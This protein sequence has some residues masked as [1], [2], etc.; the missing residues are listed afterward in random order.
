MHMPYFG[1]T[2]YHAEI[3]DLKVAKYSPARNRR[4]VGKS[5]KLNSQGLTYMGGLVKCPRNAAPYILAN[6][7]EVL[8]VFPLVQLSAPLSVL[9]TAISLFLCAHLATQILSQ[10]LSWTISPWMESNKREG[11]MSRYPLF[12]KY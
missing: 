5:L 3:R 4:G 9:L 8:Y 2:S 6:K 7:L 11:C 10:T 12:P 1:D